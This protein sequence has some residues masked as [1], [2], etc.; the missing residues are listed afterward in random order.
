MSEP[1]TTTSTLFL[2]PTTNYFFCDTETTGIALD[3]QI[4]TLY[5]CI[6]DSCFNLLHEI[7]FAIKHNSY[8][9]QAEA[10]NVNKI[11]IVSHH[12]NVDSIT[13]SE[14]KQKFEHFIFK[15]S[16]LSGRKLC[17]AGHA[18]SF[19]V[20]YIKRDLISN[21]ASYFLKHS[22]DTGTIATL[23]KQ[24]GLIPG[25]FEISL[26]NL[27][28]FY[29]VNTKTLHVAKNDVEATMAVLKCMISSLGFPKPQ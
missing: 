15:N 21:Y 25:D 27:I 1:S 2:E 23:L 11:D 24:V 6:T 18:A 16:A 29:N 8:N 3:S 13:L 10:M 28:K 19:D 12:K 26:E 20:G 14:A 5:A 7:N 4:L 22:L 9:I 17:F